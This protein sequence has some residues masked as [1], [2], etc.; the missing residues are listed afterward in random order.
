MRLADPHSEAPERHDQHR[1]QQ[2]EDEE[3]AQRERAAD[4]HPAGRQQHG[5]LC[6]QRQ[7]R[8]QGDVERALPEGAD[9]FVEHRARCALEE[10]LAPVFLGER[11][12]DVNADDRLLG[13]R[14]HITELLLHLAKDWVRD[15]AV[16]VGDRDDDG[17]DRQCDQ[18]EPPFDEEEDGHHGDD[19]EDV[20]EEEDE[21]EAEEEAHRLQVDGGTRH[22]LA[23][24]VPVVEPE[25]QPEQVRV[26]ALAHVLL[27]PERLL[28]GDQAAADHERRLQDAD[29][30]D[31]RDHPRERFRAALLLDP[32]D[33]LADEEDDRDRRRLRQDG[34]DRRDHQR[35]LV[36]PQE[37][38]QADERA[39]VR[40]RAHASERIRTTSR[41]TCVRA[42]PSRARFAG[43]LSQPLAPDGWGSGI[44]IAS[45]RS[46]GSV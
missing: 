30:H 16:A 22:Q 26:Q 15:V 10:D 25:R 4:D 42:L 41:F 34:E 32:F 46:C 5:T 29:G 9:G 36:R 28:A 1:E 11:L 43:S 35:S 8:E 18:G 14:G 13:H 17:G 45:P 21:A 27:D 20:L 19:S 40:D 44:T 31:R 6:E 7:E 24:L 39:A 12:D 33:R 2:V 37:A 3:A 38:E 23:G